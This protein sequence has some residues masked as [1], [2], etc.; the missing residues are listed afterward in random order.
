MAH[1]RLYQSR[2]LHL[3]THYAAYLEI[4]KICTFLRQ[5]KLVPN[6]VLQW[7]RC[8][9]PSK[10]GRRTPSWKR[11]DNYSYLKPITCRTRVITNLRKVFSPSSLFLYAV[12]LTRRAEKIVF[13]KNKGLSLCLCRCQIQHWILSQMPTC[14]R[15]S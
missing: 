7:T 2:F 9:R 3:N 11:S 6:S 8:T 15:K 1:S 4:Y 5:F 13:R 14:L 10:P 12:S